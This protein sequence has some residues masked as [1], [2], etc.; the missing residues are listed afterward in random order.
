MPQP[1]R[2]EP[3]LSPEQAM[4]TQPSVP[5]Q[6]CATGTP[7]FKCT[8]INLNG[9]RT[10]IQKG[11]HRVTKATTLSRYAQGEP[12]DFIG[13]QEP[14]LYIHEDVSIVVSIFNTG[15]CQFECLPPYTQRGRAALAIHHRWN[16]KCTFALDDHILVAKVQNSEGQSLIFVNAH[17][18]H[19][20]ETR[21]TQWQKL[22]TNLKS[23][24]TEDIC[25]LA[26]HNSLILPSLEVMWILSSLR[27]RAVC[28][29]LWTL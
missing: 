11:T 17:F 15:F 12:V 3:S 4:P 1:N 16:V 28:G 5:V 26:N 8:T 2:L 6:K 19:D 24:P 9:L 25:L 18:D 7:F 13:I 10:K 29:C 22:H 27:S 14:H 21:K 20:P 23:Y